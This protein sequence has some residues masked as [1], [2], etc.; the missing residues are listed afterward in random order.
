MEILK[1]PQEDH[2]IAQRILNF[3]NCEKYFSEKWKL[4]T[5]LKT[6]TIN[7]CD[8]CDKTVKSSDLKKKHILI[9]HENFKIYGHFF[10]NVKSCPNKDCVFLG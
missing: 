7:K 5:H 10:N 3:D 1:I 8:V 2:R 4:N 6:C 9:A